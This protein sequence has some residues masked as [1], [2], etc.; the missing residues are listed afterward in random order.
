MSNSFKFV[1]YEE[2]IDSDDE[3]EVPIS[4]P[5][6]TSKN[7]LFQEEPKDSWSTESY[8]SIE[9]T[10]KFNSKLAY[11]TKYGNFLKYESSIKNASTQSRL[12]DL[13]NQILKQRPDPTWLYL[14][15]YKEMPYEDFLKIIH[16]SYENLSWVKLTQEQQNLLLEQ[17]LLRQIN[18]LN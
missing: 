9:T 5:L 15:I 17:I 4:I 6:R 1:S 8:P 18:F 12:E 13:K 14:N 2:L 10:R 7:L 11:D 3:E 16:S